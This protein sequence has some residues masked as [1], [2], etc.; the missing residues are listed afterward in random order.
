MSDLT[1]ALEPY[2][3]ALTTRATTNRAVAKHL[4]VSEA[5]L[6]RILKQLN[7]QKEPPQDRKHEKELRDAR[8]IHRNNIA[9]NL[10]LKEPRAQSMQ[11]AATAANCSTRTIY[12][13]RQ[14]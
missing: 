12:R 11:A 5:Y 13:L 8:R 4:N 2:I 14:K 7:I 3:E 10:S 6:S 1:K 9:N